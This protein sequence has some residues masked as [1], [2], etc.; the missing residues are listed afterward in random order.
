MCR[1]STSLRK[2]VAL[3]PGQRIHNPSGTPRLGRPGSMLVLLLGFMLGLR[4]T[5]STALTNSL[6]QRTRKT[7]SSSFYDGASAHSFLGLSLDIALPD[8]RQ[9]PSF[10]RRLGAGEHQRLFDD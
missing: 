8:P 10:R 5:R 6:S 9:L 1:V 2:R 4:R 7:T 3:Q